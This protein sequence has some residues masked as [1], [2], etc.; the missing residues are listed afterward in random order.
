MRIVDANYASSNF[1]KYNGS[2]NWLLSARLLTRNHSHC[3]HSKFRLQKIIWRRRFDTFRTEDVSRYSY[4]NLRITKMVR[5]QNIYYTKK[6]NHTYSKNREE[7]KESFSFNEFRIYEF[8][9]E[10]NKISKKMPIEIEHWYAYVRISQCTNT[11]FARV[12]RETYRCPISPFRGI[13]YSS[14]WSTY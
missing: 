9:N 2:L 11:K 4:L 3:L 14:I 1:Q 5:P 12:P 6:I 10:N 8:E 13:P 7:N